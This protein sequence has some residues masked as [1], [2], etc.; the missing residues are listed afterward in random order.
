MKLAVG[1][2]LLAMSAVPG[3]SAVL[4]DSSNVGYN[5]VIDYA[6]KAGGASTDLISG[7]ANFTFTG[8]SNGGKTFNFSY[9]VTNDSSVSSR[10]TAW[11]L[12]VTNGTVT[13]GSSTGAFASANLNNNFPEGIGK[14][15]ICFEAD[16]NGNC[17]GGSGGL[18][19]GQNGTGTFALNFANSM[20]TL[21]FDN[22][23][24]RFQSINPTVNGSSSGVGVGALASG[25]GGSP[26]TA[27][28]PE[29]WTMMLIGF[30]LVGFALR[31]RRQRHRIA[32]QAL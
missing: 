15:E 12:D 2:V 31:G 6:G 25:G 21:S 7:L 13:S 26:I 32:P 4:I 14:V 11:G 1:A 28:E 16:S 23:A 8:V 9:S 20:A 27:P 10:L 30:G 17:T 3:Q 18:T 22:F 29:T 19:K 24:A 5:F